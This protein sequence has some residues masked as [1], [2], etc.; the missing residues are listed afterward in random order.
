ML[1]IHVETIHIAVGFDDFEIKQL[2]NNEVRVFDRISPLHMRIFSNN[3]LAIKAKCEN[4]VPVICAE[5]THIGLG[6][7]DSNVCLTLRS[8][9]QE[10][11]NLFDKAHL[12]CLKRHFEE[13]KGESAFLK[14]VGLKGQEVGTCMQK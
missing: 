8:T 10:E 13:V 14:S 4:T 5:I 1:I 12:K 7:D 9:L 3:K 11:V 6:F 2:I